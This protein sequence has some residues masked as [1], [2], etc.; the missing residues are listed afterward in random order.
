MSWGCVN[1]L[2]RGRDILD[3]I[4]GN[5]LVLLNNGQTTKTG[6]SSWRPNALDLTLVSPS[7]ALSCDWSVMDC[8]LGSSY[9]LPAMINMIVGN[10]NSLQSN[11][12]CNHV[13]VHLPIHPN[14]KQVNWKSYR[15]S[16]GS[17]LANIDFE[18]VIN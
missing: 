9:H 1:T 15:Q 6:S 14:Y 11:P 7:L 3:I 16:V 10:E 4:D 8:P 5:D 2:P 17:C 12:I 13:R 18:N